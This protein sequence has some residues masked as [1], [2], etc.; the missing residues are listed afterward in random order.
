MNPLLKKFL[1]VIGGVAVAIV[2]IVVVAAAIF[3][4]R[5]LKL[6]GE[7]TSYLQD[8]TPKIV[9]GWNAQELVDRST[10][11][12]M[13]AAKSREQI[14]Q[15]FVVFS[16][17]G[18][19]KHLDTPKGGIY[20]SSFSGRGTTTV[21]NYRVAAEFEKGAADIQIQLLR[22]DDGWKIN[23]FHVNSEALLAAMAGHD[24]SPAAAAT[25]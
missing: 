3:I 12:L 5:S 8:A 25:P 23:G 18:A 2:V 21:G 9:A 11:Q 10:P 6:D 7:A 4:P 17:L 24:P 15:M 22:V 14:D 16:R 20:S 13:N 19:L 1:M